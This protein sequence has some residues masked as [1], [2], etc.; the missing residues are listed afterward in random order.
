MRGI[1]PLPAQ[2]GPHGALGL[3]AVGLLDD[4]PHVR[5]VNRRRLAFA[6]TS[7]SDSIKAISVPL[8]RLPSSLALDIKL[9]GG[10]CVTHIGREGR[11]R[12]R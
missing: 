12:R 8:I 7:T 6:T 9:E 2:Q 4:L 1:E 10:H 11:A 3:T 5:T